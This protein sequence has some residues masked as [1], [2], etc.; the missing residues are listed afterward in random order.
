MDGSV[1]HCYVI[2]WSPRWFTILI[3]RNLIASFLSGTELFRW[4]CSSASP[5]LFFR[6]I[7]DWNSNLPLLPSFNSLRMHFS[8]LS[9]SKLA[10][11]HFCTRQ[12]PCPHWNS[13][14]LYSW[15]LADF[16]GVLSSILDSLLLSFFH[17]SPDNDNSSIFGFLFSNIEQLVATNPNFH[18]T[19]LG[20]FHG[21][22][23][24]WRL[25]RSLRH[26]RLSMQSQPRRPLQ[27]WAQHFGPSLK[28]SPAISA[29]QFPS[30]L[31]FF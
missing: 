27:S 14:S 15:V 21:F 11:M 13:W 20:D 7:L 16:D 5:M 22:D 12:L 26:P 17:H 4:F 28:R 31:Y 10:P 29:F 3:L 8:P 6:P 18:V 19:L 2:C 23:S 25:I 30:D 1:A 9:Y 24:D